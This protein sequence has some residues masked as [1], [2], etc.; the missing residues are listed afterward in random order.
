MISEPELQMRT[1]LSSDELTIWPRL[2]LKLALNTCP[3]CPFNAKSWV[4]LVLSHIRTMRSR[5]VV[6]MSR[7]FGLKEALDT[8]FG[9]R[10]RELLAPEG[11]VQITTSPFAEAETSR[12]PFL[13]K[14]TLQTA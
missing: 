13:S 11:R 12:C 8:A 14:R 1:V 4:S 3:S 6:T 9:W 10:R 2:G 5:E 7:P